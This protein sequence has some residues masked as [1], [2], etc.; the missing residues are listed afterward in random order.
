MKH[1]EVK[2]LCQ[3]SDR[4][5]RL[6]HGSRTNPTAAAGDFTPHLHECWELLFFLRGNMTHRIEG[7]SYRLRRGDLVLTRPSVFHQILPEDDSIYER[8]NAVID[9]AL[10]PDSI[11][12]RIPRDV[13]VFSF[14][15]NW[16]V[17]E[18]FEKLDSYI[19]KADEEAARIIVKSTLIEVLFLL[20]LEGEYTV[21]HTSK[22]P[23]VDKALTHVDEHLTTLE[24]VE[25]IA[26]AIYIT[27]SHLHHLF[28]SHLGVTPK[29]YIT[30]KRLLLAR[31][32]IRQGV[33]STTAAREVGYNDYATFYRNYKKHLGYSPSEELTEYFADGEDNI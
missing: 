16:R 9:D 14:G 25:E 28:I 29:Q 27:K 7:K 5:F 10:I 33:G 3:I 23:L 12:E 4:N 2:I 6:H 17:F 22:N 1:S 30:S 19:E 11:R 21:G 8:Y 26:D 18:L 13:E 32:L 31:K 20:T 15:D 24:S